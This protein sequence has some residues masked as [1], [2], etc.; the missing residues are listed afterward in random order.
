M[1]LRVLQGGP[2]APD[3]AL[4][5]AEY[6]WICPETQVLTA[7]SRV[8]TVGRDVNGDFVP[9]IPGWST[10]EGAYLLNPCHYLPDP[11]RSQPAFLVL[12]EVHDQDDCHVKGNNR[13]ILREK[14]LENSDVWFGFHANFKL[15]GVRQQN[16]V[17]LEKHFG[18]CID[19]GLMIHSFS[20]LGEFSVGPRGMPQTI[21]PEP[22][23]AVVVCD[24][25]IL[26]EYLLF[27]AT[28]MEN[29]EV[30]PQSLSLTFSTAEMRAKAPEGKV[31]HETLQKLKQCRPHFD[32]RPNVVSQGGGFEAIETFYY[33][34]ST[35][36]YVAALDMLKALEKS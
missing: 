10:M 9:V 5:V 30:I 25:L 15:S 31:L 32:F 12:C 17:A 3:Q 29:I 34:P 20:Q 35:D 26:A 22:P 1:S 24:H 27:K 33:P 16:F 7:K 8:I 11:F 36:P 18:A 28:T 2:K 23:N 13:Q 19:A 4:G 6:I 21:D 14:M